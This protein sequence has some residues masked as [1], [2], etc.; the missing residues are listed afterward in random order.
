MLLVISQECELG[1]A[2]FPE[3]SREAGNILIFRSWQLIQI[4][5]RYGVSQTKYVC[6]L[7][8]ASGLFVCTL[9]Y[10]Q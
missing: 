2:R 6:R 10:V 4:F 1:F 7:N 9:C 5:D 3:F 8:V